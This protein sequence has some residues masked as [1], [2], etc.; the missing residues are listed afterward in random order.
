MMRTGKVVAS[1]RIEVVFF[2]DETGPDR[3]DAP[4]MILDVPDGKPPKKVV[5]GGGPFDQ[6]QASLLLET[7][8]TEIGAKFGTI[9][10]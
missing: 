8:W 3:Y 5:L 9:R 1:P 4:L 10:A 6:G 7:I 2:T